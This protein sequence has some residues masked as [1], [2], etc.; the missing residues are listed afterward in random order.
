MKTILFFNNKGGVGKTTL[1]YHVAYMLGDLG[2]KTLAVDLDPQANLTSMFLDEERLIK[3]YEN[4]NKRLTILDSVKP[5]TKGLG[6]ITDAYIEKINENLFLIPGDLELSLFEDRLSDNWGKCLDRDEAAFRVISS[7]YRIIK[8]A[9]LKY[10]FDYALI[11]VGT[12]LGAINRS[13]FISS[14]FIVVPMA[15]DLFSLQGLKNLGTAV[16]RWKSEWSDRYSRNPEPTLM[17][18]KGDVKP[19]GY[20]VMQHVATEGKP[21]RA[22]KTWADKIPVIFRNFV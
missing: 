10:N 6:D 14:D 15:A 3:I 20:I 1:V 2:Y 12:N 22:Y 9:G 7:F 13:T 8:N 19:I 16:I 5:L 4:E 17:L 11:D 21:V 18:P